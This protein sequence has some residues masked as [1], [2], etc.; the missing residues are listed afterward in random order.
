MLFRSWLGGPLIAKDRLE[1]LLAAPADRDLICLV[2]AGYPAES[3]QVGRRPLAEI[4]EF[5][6]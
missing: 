2:A 5:I 1:A 3:P 4:L 6:R